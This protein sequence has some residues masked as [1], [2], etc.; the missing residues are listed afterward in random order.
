MCKQPYGNI[1]NDDFTVHTTQQLM[2]L[3]P[4]NR[5]CRFNTNNTTAYHLT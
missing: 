2:N 3:L 4:A 1:L 5:T